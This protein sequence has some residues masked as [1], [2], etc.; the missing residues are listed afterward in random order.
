MADAL[1]AKKRLQHEI[2]DYRNRREIEL[3]DKEGSIEQMRKK[4]QTEAAQYLKDVEAE[5]E[6]LVAA[7]SETQYAFHPSFLYMVMVRG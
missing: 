2:E 4:F 3:E 6:A 7:R 1:Q 5:R